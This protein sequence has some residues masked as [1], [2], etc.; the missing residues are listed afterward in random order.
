MSIPASGAQTH[1]A[2]VGQRTAA[3]ARR[4]H[5][6]ASARKSTLLNIYSSHTAFVLRVVPVP[7]T[8]KESADATPC[9]PSG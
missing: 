4:A 3:L 6:D 1:K 8:A 5:T 9:E 2:T 7:T